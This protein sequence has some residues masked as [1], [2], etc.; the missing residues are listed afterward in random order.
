MNSE[1]PEPSYT[2]F[3]SVRPEIA[4]IQRLVEQ[5]KEKLSDCTINCAI[6]SIK[7]A[8]ETSRH[9]TIL[10]F[11]PGEIDNTG[12]NFLES[13]GE[14]EVGFECKK[15]K[16]FNGNLVVTVEGESLQKLRDQSVEKINGGN[17]DERFQP[18]ISL[19]KI[20][21]SCWEAFWNDAMLEE[22]FPGNL[23]INSHCTTLT[24]A[25]MKPF[26]LIQTKKLPQ[27]VTI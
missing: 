5:I 19:G 10:A 12:D 20:R 27:T 13:M 14:D 15:L 11:K 1:E 3:V 25:L 22:V 18:H 16:V 23:E 4:D 6:K 7:W 24:I 8:R 26:R 21:C 17:Y 2:H 9:V